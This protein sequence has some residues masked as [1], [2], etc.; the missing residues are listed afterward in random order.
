MQPLPT[1]LAPDFLVQHDLSVLDFALRSFGG[2]RLHPFTEVRLRGLLRNPFLRSIL[3]IE[4][5]GA[6]DY[7][8]AMCLVG[9]GFAWFCPEKVQLADGTSLDVEVIDLTPDGQSYLDQAS[10]KGS[11]T[12]SKRAR[13][14]PHHLLCHAIGH[15]IV[16]DLG[17]G[18][19]A[20]VQT[21]Q[22]AVDIRDFDF[23]Y[24]VVSEA[25]E[26]QTPALAGIRDPASE[27]AWLEI[28]DC[29]SAAHAPRT[30]AKIIRNYHRF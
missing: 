6:T 14:D 12:P 16:M 24:S 27:N 2:L 26:Q 1:H 11:I 22:S 30:G 10:P 15:Y 8:S 5:N 23:L 19:V 18:F 7:R 21:F 3:E 20:T 29:W 25:G 4:L 28:Q 13:I 9:R 17:A